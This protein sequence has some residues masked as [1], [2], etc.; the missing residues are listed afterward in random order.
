MVCIE[1]DGRSWK[2]ANDFYV[3]YLAA[4]GAPEW[5]AL[6]ALSDSLTGGDVNQ[7]KPPLRIR[8][9]GLDLMSDEASRTAEAFASLARQAAD[10]GHDIEIQL[11]P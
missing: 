4:V 8:I 3:V 2:L 9:L 6:D 10:E 1:L 7:R 11:S 5:H